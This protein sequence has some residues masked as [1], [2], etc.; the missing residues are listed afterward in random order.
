MQIKKS[1]KHFLAIA[2]VTTLGLG[3]LAGCNKAEPPP[4]PAA[5]PAPAPAPAAAPASAPASAAPAVTGS[6]SILEPADGATV[7][8]P[9]KVKFGIDGLK[10]EPAGA[11]VAG[12]G[13][14]HLLINTGPIAEGQSI[15]MDETHLHYGK[16]QTEAE[17]KLA[18]GKYKLTAQFANGAHQSYGEALSKTIE[19]TVK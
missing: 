17:V 10:V 18:P 6:V 12:S 9:F 19:V 16:A 13:H 11:I 3:V 5:A 2:A 1:A 15:P 14:H 8:S 7:S 4:A